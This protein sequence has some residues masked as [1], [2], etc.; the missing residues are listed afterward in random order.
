MINRKQQLSGPARP[1]VA[2]ALGFL[3]CALVFLA[4]EWRGAR[5]EDPI[6]VFG[7]QA[8][9]NS[10]NDAHSTAWAV[11]Q[12][13][14]HG[15]WTAE[16]GYLN[17]GHRDGT[18]RDGIFALVGTDHRLTPRLSSSFSAGPY[19]TAD[20]Q[21]TGPNSYRDVYGLALLAGFDLGVDLSP[22]WQTTLRWQ[23]VMTFHDRDSDVFLIGIG[24]RP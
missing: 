15:R 1:I 12:K 5:A 18:K 10:L 16:Y 23:H 6:S 19:L 24:F 14:G 17:E 22:H 21:A 11:S 7:G 20:T 2:F 9:S 3:S 13:V 8:V 4:A